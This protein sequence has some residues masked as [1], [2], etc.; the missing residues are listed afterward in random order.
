MGLENQP[1]K[2]LCGRVTEEPTI[3]IDDQCIKNADRLIF[4]VALVLFYC[5]CKKEVIGSQEQ[6]YL[7]L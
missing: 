7:G 6:F 5:I 1:L 3:F 2:K 4:H